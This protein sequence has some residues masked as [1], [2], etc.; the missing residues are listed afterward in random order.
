M[1]NTEIERCKCCDSILVALLPDS[2]EG[3]LDG[4]CYDCAVRRCDAYPGEHVREVFNS[5]E[6]FLADLED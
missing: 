6:E 3:R 2:W 1:H 5:V 4:Y